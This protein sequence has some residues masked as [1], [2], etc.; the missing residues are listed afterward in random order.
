M[1]WE[2]LEVEKNHQLRFQ[3]LAQQQQTKTNATF[4]RLV[5]GSLIF[6]QGRFVFGSVYHLV[7]PPLHTI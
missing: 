4:L 7:V 5:G 1:L 3:F 6:S 2:A